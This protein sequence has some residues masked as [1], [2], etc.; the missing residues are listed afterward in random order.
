MSRPRRLGRY[1]VAMFPPAVLVP[2][3]ALNVFALHAGAQALARAAEA[4]PGGPPAAAG[5][6]LVTPRALVAFGV[7]LGLMLLLRLYDELKDVETDLRLGAAGDP[8]YAGRPIVTGAV[9]EADLRALRD[10]VTVVLVGLGAALADPRCW[11]AFAACFA[12]CWA[13]SRWFFWPPM[14]QRLVV[15]FWTHNPLSL[16]ISAVTLSAAVADGLVPATPA[17]LAWPAL[18][19]VG[20]WLPVAAWETSRKVRLPDDETAYTTYSKVLGWRRAALVPAGFAALAAGYL[21]A[22]AWRA[23]LGWAYP[24]LLVAATLLLPVRASLLLRLRPTTPRADLRPTYEAWIVLTVLGLAL[25][26]AWTHGVALQAN[27]AA[28]P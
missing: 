3:A 22:V 12:L 20:V 24:A 23:G 9:T 14:Q 17:A 6:L 5:P 25:A 8:R 28:A 2:S 7:T 15:A 19:A 10:V 26:L 1:L 16:A 27:P 21:A 4:G 13:S 18:L 11:G